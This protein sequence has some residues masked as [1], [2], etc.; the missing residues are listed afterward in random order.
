MRLLLVVVAIAQLAA[1]VVD[2]SSVPHETSANIVPGAYIVEL[3]PGSHLKRGFTSPHAELYH[4]LAR[5]GTLWKVTREY[6]CDI[7]TG[8]ALTLGSP[9]DLLKLAESGNVQV[10]KVILEEVVLL[11]SV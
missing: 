11:I 3:L 10:S 2:W 9:E 8:V 6:S 5:R 1:A 7:M 4:D